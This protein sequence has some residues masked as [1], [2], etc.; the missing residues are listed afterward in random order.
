LLRCFVSVAKR[1]FVEE[2][3]QRLKE[4][5][6]VAVVQVLVPQGHLRLQNAI[7]VVLSDV[8]VDARDLQ[9]RRVLPL[10]EVSRIDQLL[11]ADALFQSCRLLARVLAFATAAVRLMHLCF[12]DRLL[13]IQPAWVMLVWTNGY[14]LKRQ[15]FLLGDVVLTGRLRQLLMTRVTAFVQVPQACCLSTLLVLCAQKPYSCVLLLEQ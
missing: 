4:V 10:L 12:G 9:L 11:G 3:C 5:N 6:L 2:S 8:C 7:I 13:R 1:V 15:T 14:C